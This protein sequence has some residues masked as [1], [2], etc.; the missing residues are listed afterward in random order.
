MRRHLLL[1]LTL[2]VLL[3]S[4][5]VVAGSGLG[6]VQAQKA[7]ESVTRS[8]VRNLAESMANRL[9]GA[10]NLQAQAYG[11]TTVSWDCGF[12]P[13]T[14]WFPGWWRWWT[15]RGAFSWEPP[16]RSP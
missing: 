3:P 5:A 8:Y 4:V 6:L 11:T 14:C 1:F 15:P 16:G 13:G 9:D 10:W 2:S 7:L 12:S